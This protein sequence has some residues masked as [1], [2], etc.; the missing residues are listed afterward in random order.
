MCANTVVPLALTSASSLFIV[1]FGSL[2]LRRLT[3]PSAAMP[4][5]LLVNRFDEVDHM[6]HPQARQSFRG[7]TARWRARNDVAC[8]SEFK[9]A[10]LERVPVKWNR[11]SAHQLCGVIPAKARIQY[12]AA[13]PGLLD[14]P[15]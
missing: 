14:R 6:R 9:I 15:H 7:A 11:F 8:D 10:E 12:P 13:S 5:L 1:S 3:N 2:L 4:A